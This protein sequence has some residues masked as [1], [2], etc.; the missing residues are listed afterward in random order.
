MLKARLIDELKNPGTEKA[1][2]KS[3]LVVQAYNDDGKGTVLT[4]SPTIQRSSHRLILALKAILGTYRRVALYLHD[5][6]QA[7]IQST[8]R[9]LREFYIYGPPVMGLPPGTI[10]L[11]VKPLYDIP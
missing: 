1:Y 8:T 11:V 9:L 3:R 4:Q 5:I 6:S 2:E 7:Y 10:I